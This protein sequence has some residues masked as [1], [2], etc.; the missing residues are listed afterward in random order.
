MRNNDP[1]IP[2]FFA[3]LVFAAATT[4]IVSLYFRFKRRELEHRERIAALDKGAV[5]PALNDAANAPSPGLRAR[6]SFA[7]SLGYSSGSA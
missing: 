7:G 6:C 2:F 5:L 1:T 4:V 3:I